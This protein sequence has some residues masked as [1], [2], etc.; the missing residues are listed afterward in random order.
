MMP[1]FS[2]EDYRIMIEGAL[3]GGMSVEAIK[4]AFGL[5][6][7]SMRKFDDLT[8]GK[9]LTIVGKAFLPSIRIRSKQV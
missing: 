8:S 1:Q 5:D 2:D 4:K 3:E 9:P 7:E 6:A